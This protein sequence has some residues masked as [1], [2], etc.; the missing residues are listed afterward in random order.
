MKH[1]LITMQFQEKY[2]AIYITLKK[3]E[4]KKSDKFRF[5]QLVHV[6]DLCKQSHSGSKTIHTW[7]YSY[8]ILK[9]TLSLPLYL[10]LSITS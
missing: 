3:K 8:V 9:L 6:M 10:L 7:S 1:S 4:L 5:Q 2:Q